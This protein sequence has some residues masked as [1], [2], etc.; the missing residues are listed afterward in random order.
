MIIKIDDED[1]NINLITLEDP[2][3]YEIRGA[4]Q[5]P[6]QCDRDDHES[7]TQEAWVRGISK[8]SRLDPDCMMI[9]EIRDAQSARAAIPGAMTGHPI[10]TTVPAT[11]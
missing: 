4:S 2:P 5:T 6:L 3:E 8:Y 9:G 10:W 7:I 1:G 11:M